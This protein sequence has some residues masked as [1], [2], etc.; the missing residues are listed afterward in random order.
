M[1]TFPDQPL[2]Q[3]IKEDI[4]RQIKDGQL[5]PGDKIP[6]EYQ[7]MEKYGV[8]RITVSKALSELKS[9]GIITRFPHKGT[10]VTKSVLLP[11]LVRDAP[12]PSSHTAMPASMTEIACILPSITDSFSLSMV[13]GVQSVFPEDTYICH[14]F[15]SHNPTVENYLLQRCLELNISGIV[16]FPQ[17]QPFF[18]NQLLAMQ[19]QNYPLVLL[20]RYLPRLNTNYVI[21]DNKA[22]GE[23]CLRHLHKLGHQR[24]AFVTSTDRNT[25]SVKYR[26]EGI[27]E[28]AL[29]LNLP[30]YA[31]QLVEFL[32]K[33]KKFSY[34]Q[35]LFLNLITQNR[36]TAFIT[37]ESS[38]CTYLYDLLTSLDVKVPG[39]VSLMS[40]DKPVCS[41]RNPDFFTHISQS[42]YLMGR[43]AG[44]LLKNR[45]E[46]YDINTYHRVITPTLHVH[47]STGSVCL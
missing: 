45:I 32:D 21:A 1:S 13:N 3:K 27:Q 5:L 22:A 9:E 37:A 19:L 20:D 29:S 30:D 38:T 47:E 33:H 46:L 41:S 44:T 23:L 39:D 10:F 34:Y 43:E 6:T 11:P 26:I 40:F 18:S 2:Y 4:L 7:L 31:V 25:F 15:Q 14:I 16:L 8:S 35:D 42:E 17:D 36:V 24:I 12:I 28:T